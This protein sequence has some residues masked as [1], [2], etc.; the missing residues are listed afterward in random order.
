MFK[1]SIAFAIGLITGFKQQFTIPFPEG[2]V[3]RLRNISESIDL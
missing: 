2:L 3:E 1:S